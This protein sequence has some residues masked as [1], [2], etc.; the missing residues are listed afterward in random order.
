NSLLIPCFRGDFANFG[1]K[2]A[3]GRSQAKNS[4]QNSLLFQETG[5]LVW[6]K[7][8]AG[9]GSP[10]ASLMPEL[11]RQRI[12]AV[13]QQ[14]NKTGI[15]AEAGKFPVLLKI[16][17]DFVSLFHGFLEV[18]EAMIGVS[19]RSE[20]LGN[21]VGI[22]CAILQRGDLRGDAGLRM[23]LE[24][25]RIERKRGRVLMAGQVVFLP[26]KICSP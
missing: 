26:G 4:L 19:P 1:Q 14:G 16:R 24:Y 12:W 11:I 22:Q 2:S 8:K 23:S 10:G 20:H 17:R 15:L 13:L 21:D 3:I 25:F 6:E 9:R 18:Q 7:K 5:N